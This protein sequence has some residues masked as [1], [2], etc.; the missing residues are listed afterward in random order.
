MSEPSIED[1]PAKLKLSSYQRAQ[2][3]DRSPHDLTNETLRG[4]K[5]RS[6]WERSLARDKFISVYLLNE[7]YPRDAFSTTTN[8]KLSLILLS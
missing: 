4:V 3:S 2:D 6:V 1:Y 5:W 8:S 7:G